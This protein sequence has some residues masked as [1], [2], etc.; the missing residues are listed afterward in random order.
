MARD[1]LWISLS[2]AYWPLRHD[3]QDS[4][5]SFYTDKAQRYSLHFEERAFS[6]RASP[7]HCCKMRS[8]T[9]RCDFPFLECLEA[10]YESLRNFN[11]RAENEASLEEI[12]YSDGCLTLISLLLEVV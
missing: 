12:N 8:L 7:N 4:H 10:Y 11:S 2:S 3:L 5:D 9:F 1:G 6:G